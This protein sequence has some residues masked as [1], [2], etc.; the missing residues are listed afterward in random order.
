M[1]QNDSKTPEQE[2]SKEETAA[3]NESVD[4]PASSNEDDTNPPAEGMLRSRL[5]NEWVDAEAAN[6]DPL[7]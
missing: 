4:T 1:E 6:T 7:L 3:S 2:E 5:T